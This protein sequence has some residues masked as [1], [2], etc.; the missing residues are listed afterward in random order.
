[1]Y[2]GK[3]KALYTWYAVYLMEAEESNPRFNETKLLLKTSTENK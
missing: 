3:L 2:F 1:M